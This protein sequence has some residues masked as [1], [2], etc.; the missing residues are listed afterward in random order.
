MAYTKPVVL[1]QNSKQGSIAAKQTGARKRRPPLPEWTRENIILEGGRHTSLDLDGGPVDFCEYQNTPGGD[2]IKICCA[3]HERGVRAEYAWFGNKYSGAV[4]A[5]QRFTTLVVNS[6]PARC[7]ILT[8]ELPDGTERNLYFD[9]SAMM[10]DLRKISSYEL[11]QSC[12]SEK[13]SLSIKNIFNKEEH[14]GLYQT[15]SACP[16]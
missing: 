11:S 10:D 9:I 7:D 12:E 3:V 2:F 8:I 4:L 14:H 16:E 6:S 15:G 5:R 13:C 1:A